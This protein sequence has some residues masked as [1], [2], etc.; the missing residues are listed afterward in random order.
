MVELRRKRESLEISPTAWTMTLELARLCGWSPRGTLQ[1][2]WPADYFASN[3]QTVMADDAV[4]LAD[5]LGRAELEAPGVIE[6]WQGGRAQPSVQLRTPAEGFRWFQTT[7]GREQL[8]RL[9]LFVR[10]GA[11]EIH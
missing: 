6:D 2:G 5:A 11:F 8:R 7:P 4:N 3:G 1:V 10:R 9:T